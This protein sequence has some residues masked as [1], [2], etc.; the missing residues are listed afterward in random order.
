MNT[1][2]KLITL[3]CLALPLAGCQQGDPHNHDELDSHV[4]E[5]ATHAGEAF[6]Q[7]TADELEEFGVETAIAAPGELEIQITLPGEVLI[8]QDKYAHIVP[9]VAGVVHSASRSVGDK[10][11]AGQ[12]LAVLDSRELA[13]IKAEYL[14]GL[15]RKSLAEAGYKREERLFGQKIS[16]EQEFL[17]AKQSLAEFEIALRSV[18][19]KLLALGLSEG[20]INK[21]PEQPEHALVHFELKAPIAGT[22]IEK[23][24][25]QGEA[26][27]ADAEAFIIA[28]L[29]SVWVDLNVYQKDLDLVF[30]GQQVSIVSSG[31]QLK[32]GGIIQYVRPIV[33]E[34]TRTAIARIVLAN[35]DGRWRPGL[36]VNGTVAVDAATVALLVP[37]SAVINLEG[38]SVVFVEE[39]GGFEARHVTLGKASET[40]VEVVSGLSEGEKYV[41][42]GGFALKAEL[43]KDNLGD[44]HAH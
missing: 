6:V 40:H 7:F 5:E 23:H 33:G 8:N 34:E 21:L 9:R 44:G 3:V 20:Y 32:A 16:S 36:F 19:Q 10:V 12:V 24:I 27:A 14:A 30:E 39:E 37:R 15:E 26:I 35:P 28:N 31:G 4:E 2:I 11:R 22:I 29:T 1:Y 25:S 41:A 13:D 42:K 18:R 17:E 43:G 38:E